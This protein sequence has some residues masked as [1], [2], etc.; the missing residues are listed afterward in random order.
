VS[1]DDTRPRIV[2]DTRGKFCPVPIIETSQAIKNLHA[3]GVVEVISDDPAIVED[4]PAWC[5]S[6]GHTIRSSRQVGEDYHYVVEKV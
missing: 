3:G 5:K 6:T 1:P 4:L 2:L